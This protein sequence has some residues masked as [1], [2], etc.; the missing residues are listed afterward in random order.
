VRSCRRPGGVLLSFLVSDAPSHPLPQASGSSA[1]APSSARDALPVSEVFYSVQGEGK[2]TGVP[3][4]FIRLSGCNL[5]CWWCD[6]PY[7]S[8]DAATDPHTTRMAV[9]DLLERVIESGADHA[10][11]TGGEPM[12]FPG[13]LDLTDRLKA[14]GIH[15]TIETAGTVDRLKA[16]DGQL[17][18]PACDL[19]SISPKLRHSTPVDDPRDP[20]GRLAARHEKTRLNV[21]ALQSL[22]DHHPDRQLKFVVASE[23]DLG[24]IDDLLGRL[25]GFTPADVLLMPEG[26]TVPPPERTAWVVRTCLDRGWR[27]CH[28][29]HVELFGNTRGT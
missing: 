25:T 26:V 16:P 7:A 5:R 9:G 3:S 6:T 22:I 20:S 11:L 17:R 18:H 15:I 2:L 8:W 21:P 12:I 13:L 23:S 29:L 10:V 28:R 24:E 27:Y 1:P 14:A 19:I 4:V